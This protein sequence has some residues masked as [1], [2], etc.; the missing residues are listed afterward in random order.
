[1]WC[2]AFCIPNSAENIDTAHAFINEAI[3]GK[4]QAFQAK[5][6]ICGT[7]STSSAIEL[8]DEET[9]QPVRLQPTWTVLKKTPFLGI[10]PRESTEFATYDEWVQAYQDLKSGI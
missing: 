3:G 8:M 10:P 5:H 9:K 7:P 6:T 4:E 2:D 1:M